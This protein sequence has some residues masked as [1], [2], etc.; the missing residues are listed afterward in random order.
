MRDD[1]RV[2]RVLVSAHR[3]GAGDDRGAENSLAAFAHA[4]EIGCDYV[5]FD[6]RRAA[7]GSLVIVHDTPT[8]LEGVPLTAVLSILAGR[9][10]AHVD[11]KFAGGELG[12]VIDIAAALGTDNV[13]ITTAEDESI[14][15]ILT[16]AMTAAPELL[17]G[18]STSARGDGLR[19]R[20]RV[21]AWFPRRRLRRSGANVVVAHRVWARWWLR[22][23]ARR[24]GLPLLVWTVDDPDELAYW[25]HDRD[26]WLVATNHPERALAARHPN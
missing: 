5:E 13:V 14:R 21:A 26:T 2:H 17:V 16:W 18:L 8:V 7:D 3:G 12:A 20:D 1:G 9:A 10:K 22:S 24:R 6:V 23:Y 25:M 4:V 11:L 15:P 19:L